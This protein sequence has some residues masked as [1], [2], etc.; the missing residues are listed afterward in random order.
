MHST[1]KCLLVHTTT[2]NTE[3]TNLSPQVTLDSLVRLMVKSSS[4]V[5]FV[6]ESAQP[7][8]VLIMA[9]GN[10]QMAEGYSTNKF[11]GKSVSLFSVGHVSN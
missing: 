5:F 8:P 9:D 7:D 11:S 4:V 10:V 3:R 1:W 2:Y 6:Y